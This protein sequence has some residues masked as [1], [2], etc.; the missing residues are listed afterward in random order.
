MQ[1]VTPSPPARKN[2]KSI[3][4][5]TGALESD[6]TLASTLEIPLETVHNIAPV[7]ALTPSDKALACVNDVVCCGAGGSI[8]PHHIATVCSIRLL[9]G[10]RNTG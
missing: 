3:I 10:L 6:V 7:L 9:R 5:V 2:T 1:V 4:G 8:R